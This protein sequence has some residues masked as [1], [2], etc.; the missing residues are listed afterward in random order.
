V[1][2][3][4]EPRLERLSADERWVL[5]GASDAGQEFA[6]HVVASVAPAG[7]ELADVEVVEQLCDGLAHRQDIL[8]VTGEVTWPDGITSARYAFRHVLYQQ[9]IDQA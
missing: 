9:V 6:A 8:R 7:S 5:E 3:V 2:A 1:R 4:I